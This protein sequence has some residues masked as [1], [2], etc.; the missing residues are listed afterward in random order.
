[1]TSVVQ[2]L[3]NNLII[4][5]RHVE[6]SVFKNSCGFPVLMGKLL[7][8]CHCCCPIYIQNS[9]EARLVSCLHDWQNMAQSLNLPSVIFW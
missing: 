1:M 3:L 4:I 5:N 2:V 7:L 8:I 9:C 6:Q